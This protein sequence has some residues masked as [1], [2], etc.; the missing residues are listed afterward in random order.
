MKIIIFWFY[1]VCGV[2]KHASSISALCIKIQIS[3]EQ[4]GCPKSP[5]TTL[6]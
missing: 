5:L 6:N 3:K 2:H 1:A 4:T